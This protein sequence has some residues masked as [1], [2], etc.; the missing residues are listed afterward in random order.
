MIPPLDFIPLAEE[1]GLIIPIGEWVL[2]QACAQNKAWQEA[3]NEPVPISVNVSL[4]QFRQKD[5]VEL[6]ETV[7][8]ET[9]LAPKYLE[10]EITESMTMDMVYTE[11]FLLH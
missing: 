6:V 4:S 2:R 3:G 7:L 1:T 9:G 11:R 10:L 5:F 8:Q